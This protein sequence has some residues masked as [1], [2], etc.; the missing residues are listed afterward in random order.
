MADLEEKFDLQLYKVSPNSEKPGGQF[1]TPLSSRASQGTS[2][3]RYGNTPD[4]EINSPD[5]LKNSYASGTYLLVNDQHRAEVRRWLSGRRIRADWTADNVSASVRLFAQGGFAPSLVATM[6]LIVAMCLFWLAVRAR[7]RALQVLAGVPTWKISLRDLQ[8]LAYAIGSGG[9]IV[10]TLSSAI[11]ATL[12]GAEFTPYFTKTLGQLIVTFLGLS[13]A[14]ATLL[15]LKAW[16]TA[17]MLARREPAVG[18]LIG[19]SRGVRVLIFMLVAV[20]IWPAAQVYDLAAESAKNARAWNKLS[21]KAALVNFG[22]PGNRE[23]EFKK[24][25]PE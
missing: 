11:V 25:Q 12:K 19:V 1:F 17:R 16:P 22:S 9:V 5:Y 15:S 3:P 10:L 8:S 23:E 20:S 21:D 14:G 2:F 7:A 24:A 13:L 6:A 4:G 18:Q